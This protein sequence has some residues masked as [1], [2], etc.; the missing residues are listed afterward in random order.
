VSPGQCCVG[1]RVV[2]VVWVMAPRREITTK[3]GGG[4]T[5]AGTPRSQRTVADEGG[6][7]GE[8]TGFIA[9]DR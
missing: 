1:V 4:V 7:Y 2:L 3:R 8:A 9:E 5:V 6:R